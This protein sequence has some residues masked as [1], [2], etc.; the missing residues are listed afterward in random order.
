MS[1]L[2]NTYIIEDGYNTNYISCLLLS[3]F[4]EKNT[5]YQNFLLN[6]NVPVEI[7]YLQ[8]LIKILIDDFKNYKIMNSSKQNYLRIILYL[9]GFKNHKTISDNQPIEDLYDF[10]FEKIQ[11]PK[12]EFFNL[13]SLDG[14]NIESMNYLTLLIS[15]PDT[16]LKKILENNLETKLLNNIPNFIAIKLIKEDDNFLCD[17][18]KKISINSIYNYS[19]KTDAKLIWEISSIICYEKEINNYFSFIFVNNNW[20]IINQISIPC[21][22]K[23]NIRNY[24][25]II[26]LKARFL[27]YKFEEKNT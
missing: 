23:I 4:L 5:I 14:T 12:L 20:Y 21:M 18:Q 9:K 17:I 7:T 25:N 10:L 22:Q 15:N 11:L 19:N 26:K 24:E 13:K 6:D 2:N 8:E 16:S 3:L 1:F 27:V